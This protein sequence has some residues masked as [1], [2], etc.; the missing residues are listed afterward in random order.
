MTDEYSGI[1]DDQGSDITCIMCGVV[2]NLQGGEQDFYVQR[3]LILPK[4]CNSCR[5]ER[6][7]QVTQV[8]KEVSRNPAPQRRP[9]TQQVECDHCNR[10]TLIPFIPKEGSEV[11]CRICWEGVRNVGTTGAVYV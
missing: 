8:T 3:G 10:R 7:A 4:R 1:G 9:I 11:Y 6:K 2:F 5:A